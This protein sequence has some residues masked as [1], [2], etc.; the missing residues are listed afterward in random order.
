MSVRFLGCT[1]LGHE[2][3]ARWRNFNSVE[4][5]DEYLIKQWNSVVTSKKDITVILGDVT[6]EN[7]K[8]YY[9]LDLLNGRKKVVMGNHDLGRDSKE[10]LNYVESLHG[11]YAYKGYILTHIPIHPN[12]VHF[13]RSNLHCHIH[14]NNKLEEAYVHD[15]YK[16]EGS[17]IKP[18]LHKYWN[19][20]A[21]LLDFK[22]R[23][24]E[25][26]REIYQKE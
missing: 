15:R 25:E 19:V 1:H 22:P 24:L 2:G 14:H 12:E 17:A 9:K 13:Y 3:V 18:S 7:S 5:H 20:D 10:L 16:D 4:E 26:L 8:N 21:M 6:M 23:T 11:A